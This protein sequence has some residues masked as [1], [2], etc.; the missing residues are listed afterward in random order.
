MEKRL[1]PGPITIS[2]I[3]VTDQLKL[4]KIAEAHVQPHGVHGIT[5]MRVNGDWY[6][7]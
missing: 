5:V 4:A 6:I 1:V 2:V 3:R 7:I